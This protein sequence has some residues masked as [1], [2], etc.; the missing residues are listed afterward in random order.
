[1]SAFMGRPEPVFFSSYGAAGEPSFVKPRANSTGSLRC[2]ARQLRPRSCGAPYNQK[3]EPQAMLPIDE[4]YHAA[5]A[6]A[7]L[8]DLSDYG[9]IGLS[10]RDA[11]SFL[12]NLCTQDV[13]NLSS[14]A[15]CEA[16]L[17]TNKARVSP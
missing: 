8:F 16:F 17:T 2:S 1:M 4:E 10:G 11:R 5:T 7:A 9:K 13:K 14:G 6:G 12:Q 3:M 15:G